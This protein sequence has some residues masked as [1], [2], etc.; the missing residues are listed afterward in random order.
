MK[1]FKTCITLIFLLSASGASA[2]TTSMSF[3][4]FDNKKL[5]FKRD[6]NKTLVFQAWASWC[7]TCSETMKKV[8]TDLD[9]GNSDSIEMMTVSIDDNAGDAK[10]YMEKHKKVFKGLDLDA[11]MDP[12]AG[13]LSQFDLKGIPATII[14]KPNGKVTVLQGKTSKEKIRRIVNEDAH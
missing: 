12:A 11:V 5:N 4:G 8:H 9:V 10:S 14:I 3:L 2:D 7:A 1:M 13:Q 6:Q